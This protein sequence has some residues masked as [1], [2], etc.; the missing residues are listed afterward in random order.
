MPTE[1]KGGS[2]MKPV[3]P[4]SFRCP[5]SGDLCTDG[6]CTRTLCRAEKRAL[7]DGDRKEAV[8]ASRAAMATARWIV[9]A[10]I[11]ERLRN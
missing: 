8:K 10:M 2:G 1:P 3:V 4:R 7:A 5:E 11:K 6:D 9:N